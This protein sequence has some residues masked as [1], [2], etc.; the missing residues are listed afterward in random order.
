M[1]I[2]YNNNIYYFDR[3]STLISLV[4]RQDLI[5]LP[6]SIWKEILILQNLVLSELDLYK[7]LKAKI[8]YYD[9]S[10][11]VNGFYINGTNYW[12]D[13]NTRVGLAHLANCT[14]GTMSL[15]LGD[16]VLEIESS[17][18]KDI[19][20]QIERYASQCYLQTQKHL[21]AIKELKTVEDLINYDYTRGYPD[22]LNFTI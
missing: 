21:L 11:N 3:N 5:N 1:E 16:T 17:V 19:L 6:M 14:E 9:T 12:L 13:K 20:A 18:V 7:V 10:S 4:N 2:T 8:E 22:K 15:V